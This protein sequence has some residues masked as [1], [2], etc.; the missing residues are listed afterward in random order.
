MWADQIYTLRNHLIHGQ[1][2]SPDEFLFQGEQH[3]VLAAAVLFINAL[4]R[5]L[6]RAR[7]AAGDKPRFY[8]EVSWKTWTDDTDHPPSKHQGFTVRVDVFAEAAAK[9]GMTPDE[10]M[11]ELV[12]NNRDTT[13]GIEGE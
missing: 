12:R 4:K 13:R 11:E 3:H 2:V 6:N 10:Y 1:E 7:L 8:D 9:R 5:T